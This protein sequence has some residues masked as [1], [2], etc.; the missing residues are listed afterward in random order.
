MIED[1]SSKIAALSSEIIKSSDDAQA[2]LSSYGL[3]VYDSEKQELL[4]RV[5]YMYG[6]SLCVPE[7]VEFVFVS[8]DIFSK[9]LLNVT[10]LNYFA[11][12]MFRSANDN[13][14]YFGFKVKSLAFKDLQAWG[15]KLF[16]ITENCAKNGFVFPTKEHWD[17]FNNH[18][19]SSPIIR[20][21]DHSFVRIEKV[22]NSLAP[23]EEFSN[24]YRM[25]DG[26]R[27]YLIL[28]NDC[29]LMKNMKEDSIDILTEISFEGFIECTETLK[30]EIPLIVK[31]EDLSGN[32]IKINYN[33]SNLVLVFAEDIIAIYE[34]WFDYLSCN[35]IL[36]I[37][38]KK[39]KISR[40]YYILRNPSE[41]YNKVCA[42]KGSVDVTVTS[43]DSL[44]RA[45]E[46]F[47]SEFV[48]LEYSVRCLSMY[49]SR[50]FICENWALNQGRPGPFAYSCI[51]S[52]IQASG[53][54]KSRTSQLL[55]LVMDTLYM[56]SKT[57]SGFPLECKIFEN[58]KRSLDSWIRKKPAG[59][60]SIAILLV[61]ILNF[62]YR[63]L[64]LCMK[65][66]KSFFEYMNPNV[67]LRVDEND[68]VF[69]TDNFQEFIDEATNGLPR[70][71][72]IIGGQIFTSFG[73]SWSFYNTRPFDNKNIYQIPF[74]TKIL[75]SHP[76]AKD[77]SFK[78]LEKLLED[79]RKTRVKLMVEKLYSNL[80]ITESGEKE[81]KLIS[82][83]STLPY[84]MI[85]FDE[86]Q[87]LLST[88]NKTDFY[89]VTNYDGSTCEIDLFRLIR[90]S[91]RISPFNWRFIWGMFLSTNTNITNFIPTPEEDPSL[92]LLKDT[93]ILPPFLMN[94]NFDVFAQKFYD[95]AY[96]IA[97]PK[98]YIYNLQRIID[99]ISC[100]RPLFYTNFYNYDPSLKGILSEKANIP[101]INTWSSLKDSLSCL[102]KLCE[103]KISGKE[104]SDIVDLISENENVKFAVISAAIGILNIPSVVDKRELLRNHMAWL[105]AADVRGDGGLEITYTS[106]GFFNSVMAKALEQ[107]T[108][109]RELPLS[110]LENSYSK[111]FFD[112]GETGEI[113]CRF[114]FLLAILRTKIVFPAE[115]SQPSNDL[116]FNKIS[117]IF[118]PRRVD[119]FLEKF[120]CRN[121]VKT[122]LDFCDAFYCKTTNTNENVF[123]DS[124]IAFSYFHRCKTVENPVEFTRAMLYRGCARITRAGHPGAD[125]ILPLVSGDDRLGNI[126]V[127]VKFVT[128]HYLK[129][130]YCKLSKEDREE[131]MR[132]LLNKFKEDGINPANLDENSKC[133]TTFFR[134]SISTFNLNK[135]FGASAENKDFDKTSPPNTQKR[136]KSDDSK[137]RR[138]NTPNP[139][140]SSDQKRKHPDS[141]DD[142]KLNRPFPSLRIF[143]AIREDSEIIS[144]V[145][146][147]EFGPILLIET[148]GEH[149]F[150]GVNEK[151]MISNIIKKSSRSDVPIQEL[152][153]QYFGP[154]HSRIS[155]DKPVN[156]VYFD[157]SIDDDKE[158]LELTFFKDH[159]DDLKNEF[160]NRPDFILEFKKLCEPIPVSN[161]VSSKDSLGASSSRSRSQNDQI[162]SKA[163]R[164]RSKN[165]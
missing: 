26:E 69:I 67:I 93:F 46:C 38:F 109:S 152:W 132:D 20:L 78:A 106:E 60:I 87:N 76:Y 124:L 149:P 96:E 164:R 47:K 12:L 137:I 102:Y 51:L 160:E 139:E 141:V 114:L 161:V 105:V 98:E 1:I 83:L 92:K 72:N 4:H 32:M 36:M 147:D 48:D 53:S 86:A 40:N 24:L 123:S 59:F 75:D 33:H 55:S 77:Y 27:H 23:M 111:T 19:D 65:R 14:F 112:T 138:K 56:S 120:V 17:F 115:F 107:Y 10:C 113:V 100:G 129:V 158:K 119:D 126:L 128:Q 135:I 34:N 153:G 165:K 42:T 84:T 29:D 52:Q 110:F 45:K 116:N 145:E 16:E 121:M 70:D 103:I 97:K 2:K 35:F 7:D 68:P 21:A 130:K 9:F 91:F 50:H 94:C 156:P 117:S 28:K 154:T 49:I 63:I 41:A 127:Q 31:N 122:F 43:E 80:S 155:S 104:E 79:N 22:K 15:Q 82:D 146:F 157:K 136:L 73:D 99:I 5:E 162:F 90:R 88:Y 62:L 134:K 150:L 44:N 11:P 64:F 54:G 131:Q 125:F 57:N 89:L 37:N 61:V 39:I 148:N 71:M 81:M 144:T 95:R 108:K 143:I 25:F 159:M 58:F 118:Y 8:V 142:K 133:T 30:N 85:I 140:Q 151:N 6:N 13:G 18:E 163:N 3:I 101:W 66:R 74:S